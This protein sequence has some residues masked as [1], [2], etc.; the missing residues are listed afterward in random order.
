MRQPF[1]AGTRVRVSS[2]YHWARA[3]L[4]TVREP[5]AQNVDRAN[6][7]SGV[8]REVPSRHGTL[9]SQ[10]IEFDTPQRDGDGDGP[11]QAGEI[12]LGHLEPA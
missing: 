7:W 12:E 6:G 2:S 10:W 4:G 9:L 5:P 11:Y 1:E 3:A 8:V